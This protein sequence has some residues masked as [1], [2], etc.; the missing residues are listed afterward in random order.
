MIQINNN[1]LVE[2]GLS[3]LSEEDKKSLL[4]KIYETLELRVGQTLA[5]Q[6]SEAQLN[7]FD[8]YFEAKD[9]KGAFVWLETNFPNY[10]EIVQKEFDALKQELSQSVPQILEA[11]T[12]AD[13]QPPQS[14]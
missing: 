12:G 11:A 5:S 9:E 14:Q 13:N 1:L 10:K 8:R 6:M 3:S 7:E 4:A 2:L